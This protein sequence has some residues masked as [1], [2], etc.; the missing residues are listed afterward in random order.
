MRG[1]LEGS[2]WPHRSRAWN[3]VRHTLIGD[4]ERNPACRSV[5]GLTGTSIGPFPTLVSYKKP[6]Q[7]LA[8]TQ[9]GN[10][11]LVPCRETCDAV[12][13][14]RAAGSGARASSTL[15]LPVD[16]AEHQLQVLSDARSPAA[17]QLLGY[18]SAAQRA[19]G[20]SR[21]VLHALVRFLRAP[22]SRKAAIRQE[23]RQGSLI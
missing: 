21:L 10:R 6:T 1:R 11:Q 8:D 19:A 18:A 15:L 22:N 23:S 13:A 9:S 7:P 17:L 2:W 4:E 12:R 3:E 5:R 16:D 20:V 14:P